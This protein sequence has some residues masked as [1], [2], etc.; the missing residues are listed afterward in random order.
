MRFSAYIS[1]SRA[2]SKNK[3]SVAVWTLQDNEI[4]EQD[5]KT[6]RGYLEGELS[7]AHGCRLDAL[8]SLLYGE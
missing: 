6:K 3:I 8:G 7:V 1:C 5:V 2:R 4:L